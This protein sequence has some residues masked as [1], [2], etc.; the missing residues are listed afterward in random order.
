MF[1]VNRSGFQIPVWRDSVNEPTC[2]YIKSLQLGT[3]LVNEF[4]RYGSTWFPPACTP[5]FVEYI[6]FLSPSGFS[7]GCLHGDNLANRAGYNTSILN[8][9]RRTETIGGTTQRVY[10][11]QNRAEELRN[12][13]GNLLPSSPLAIGTEI[14]T[15]SDTMG[16]T[17]LDYWLI[18]WVKRNGIWTRADNVNGTY[19]FVDTG[20]KVGSSPNSISIKTSLA[21]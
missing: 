15:D 7:A 6:H 8:F 5:M 20:L 11:I 19:A 18:R 21:T 13:A 16:Q 1:R 17:Y 4:Y 10:Q 2:A 12:A 14:A 9:P 3:L